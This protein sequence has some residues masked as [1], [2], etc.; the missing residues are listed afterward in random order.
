MGMFAVLSK[1]GAVSGL[2]GGAWR[3]RHF[4]LS[5]IRAEF[6][7]RFIRSRLGGL[8]VIIH[9]LTQVLIYALILSGVLGSRLPGIDNRYAYAIYLCAGQL[10]W[11]LFSEIVTRSLNVFIDN[12]NFLK[13]ISFPRITL[14]LIL[15]G[16]SLLNN[17]FL[18]AAVLVVFAFLGHLP[19]LSVFWLPGLTFVALCLGLGFGLILGILNVFIRDVG[20]VVSIILQLLFWFTPIVYPVT[21]IPSPLRRLLIFNPV[22]PVVVGYQDVLVYGRAPDLKGLLFVTAFS[23]L[24]LGFGLLLFRKANADMMDVL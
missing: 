1:G 15:L 22:Y 18:L 2:M 8:W 21:I 20:Q 14:P 23:L 9:P 24:A 4:I 16:S 19:G 17:T 13:K 7:N 10:G 6:V 5:S 12:A 11:N 3:Y